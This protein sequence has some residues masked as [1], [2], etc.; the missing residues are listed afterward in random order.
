MM[1]SRASTFRR[2]SRRQGRAPAAAFDPQAHFFTA[3]SGLLAPKRRGRRRRSSSSVLPTPSGS[4]RAVVPL[5]SSGARHGVTHSRAPADDSTHCAMS[6]V[7]RARTDSR[8]Q[9]GPRRARP[10]MRDG[11]RRVREPRPAGEDGAC[12]AGAG[13]RRG[14]DRRLL[15][16]HA[17]IE[18]TRA[19][20]LRRQVAVVRG[21]TAARGPAFRAR[22][23]QSS[24][25]ILACTVT[26]S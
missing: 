12:R 9:A 22:P 3:W 11:A 23:A 24:S 17:A 26:S 1:I 7:Q 4:S 2:R 14:R 8:V 19:A 16:G 20:P 15:H 6:S 13:R 18:S 21:R 5:G 10:S 25:T